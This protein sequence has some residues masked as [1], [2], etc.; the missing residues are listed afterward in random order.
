[1]SSEKLYHHGIKGQRWGV[2]RFQN[3][4]GSLTSEGE[5]RYSK[6]QEKVNDKKDS[7]ERARKATK[8][9]KDFTLSMVASHAVSALTGIPVVGIPKKTASAGQKAAAVALNALFAVSV[10]KLGHTLYK[11]Q[12]DSDTWVKWESPFG[13]VYNISDILKRRRSRVKPLAL[14]SGNRVVK[15]IYD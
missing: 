2:R 8:F 9:T 5:K 4:D 12:Y 7:K 14:G 11:S 10:A 6:G 3:K 1:M 15:T 13:N